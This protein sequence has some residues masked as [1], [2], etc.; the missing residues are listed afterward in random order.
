MK[1]LS[2]EGRLIY[3]SNSEITIKECVLE[4]IKAKADLSMANLSG[5]NLSGADLSMAN[6]SRANLS[7]AKNRDLAYLPIYCKWSIC[8]I[9]GKIKVGSEE[10]TETEWA[11]G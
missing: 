7:R 3:D 8:F 5:A 10:K 9:G 11:S 1:I 4:A 2:T 6:L